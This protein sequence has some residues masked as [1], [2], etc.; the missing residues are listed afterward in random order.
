[1]PTSKNLDAMSSYTGLCLANSRAMFNLKV[2]VNQNPSP[3]DG[4]SHVQAEEG[5]PSG[6]IGLAKDTTSRQRF[7]AIESTDVVQAKEAALEDIVAALVLTVDPPSIRKF[8]SIVVFNCNR[9]R[10]LVTYVK[11]K[12]NFWKTRS[13]NCRSSFPKSFLSSL[14]TRKVAHA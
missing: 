5:H 11:F 10:I 3:S 1:M 14:K 6:S 8:S 9:A 12:S 2:K 7:R 13:R 4:Y